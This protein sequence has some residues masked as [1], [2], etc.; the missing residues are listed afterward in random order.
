M[1]KHVVAALLLAGWAAQAQAQTIQTVRVSPGLSDKQSDEQA[2]LREQQTRIVGTT[3]QRMPVEMRPTAGAPYSAEAVTE[4]T[5]VL[6]DGNR[7]NHKTTT[8]VYR[9]SE[10]R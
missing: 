9:D 2:V 3:H 10:G 7:I 6:P 5:Q 4:S 1:K 8:R